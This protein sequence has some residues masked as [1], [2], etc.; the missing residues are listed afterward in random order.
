MPV[1]FAIIS[2]VTLSPCDLAYSISVFTHLNEDYQFDWLN[3]LRRIIKS[4]GILLL[5]VHGQNCWENLPSEYVLKIQ[6]EGF[7][8]INLEHGKK[9]FPKWSG[10]AAAFHSKEYVFD[11]F[12]KYFKILDYIPRGLRKHQDIIILQKI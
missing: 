6:K 10:P 3:E 9:I 5:T 4:Q 2:G 8:F 1:F 11:K 7:L 12:S